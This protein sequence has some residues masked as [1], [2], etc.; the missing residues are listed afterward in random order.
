AYIL[1]YSLCVELLIS[2]LSKGLMLGLCL[3][4]TTC[5][6]ST[7]ERY[8]G[9]IL[10]PKQEAKTATIFMQIQEATGGDEGSILGVF[11]EVDMFFA[12]AST[13]G[14]RHI[15]IMDEILKNLNLDLQEKLLG[16]AP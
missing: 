13:V 4:R 12:V 7:K 3:E 8:M 1:I 10:I 16:P 11:K 2:S 5:G 9:K 15:Y 6:F 14:V